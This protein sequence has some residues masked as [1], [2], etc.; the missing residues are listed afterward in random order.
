MPKRSSLK[1]LPEELLEQANR[2]MRDG[3]YTI[4]DITEHLQKL[5]A[6][7]SRSAVGRYHKEFQEIAADIRI[8]KEWARAVGQELGDEGHT[9]ATQFIIEAFQPILMKV[10]RQFAEADEIDVG[11]VSD[12]AK[13]VKDFQVAMKSNVDMH[14]RIRQQALKDA[15][16]AAGQVAEGEG[17]SSTTIDAIKARILGVKDA[18]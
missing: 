11:A 5:G 6:S 2:L 13:S 17:L 8:T 9:D 15:A 18:A 14:A 12:F 16:A 4:S 7:V 10:R 3:K 1:N